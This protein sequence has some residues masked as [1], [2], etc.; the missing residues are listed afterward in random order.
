[1]YHIYSYFTHQS[2]HLKIVIFQETKQNVVL[3]SCEVTEQT[4]AIVY[5][6][7]VHLG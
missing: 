2:S 6:T 1:M 3:K 4:D 5:D 7:V